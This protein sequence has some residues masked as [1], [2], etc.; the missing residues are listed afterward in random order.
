MTAVGLGVFVD[1]LGQIA[2]DVR[3]PTQL[4]LKRGQLKRTDRSCLGLFELSRRLLGQ[5]QHM[6]LLGIGIAGVAADQFGE[7]SAV[8][9]IG[10]GWLVGRDQQPGQMCSAAVEEA[11]ST[12]RARRYSCV[13]TARSPVKAS[14]PP[15][16]TRASTRL[17]SSSTA[18]PQML[19]GVAQTRFR[20]ADDFS[21]QLV[22]DARSP[23]RHAPA[24]VERDRPVAIDSRQPAARA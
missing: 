14:A 19:D 9:A 7:A 20:A 10:R 2:I 3:G 13:A 6:Q 23:N 18:A 22:F 17:P 11:G 12:S 4:P 21:R 16:G 1:D 15:N 8:G 5:R 24:H